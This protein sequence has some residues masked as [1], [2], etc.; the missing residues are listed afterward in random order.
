MTDKQKTT[1]EKPHTPFDMPFAAMMKQM[2]GGQQGGGCNCA[3]MMAM[4]G[5]AQAPGETQAS[6]EEATQEAKGAKNG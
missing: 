1:Q 4:C 5:G 3:E 6:T 2:M